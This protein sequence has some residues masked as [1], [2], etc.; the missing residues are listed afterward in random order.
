MQGA[1]GEDKIGGDHVCD[2]TIDP[3]ISKVGYWGGLPE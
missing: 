1:G 2:D 3:G